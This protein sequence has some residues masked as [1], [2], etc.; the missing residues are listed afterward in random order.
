MVIFCYFLYNRKS[1]TTENGLTCLS[2][3]NLQNVFGWPF[4][5]FSVQV[6]QSSEELSFHVKHI[7]SHYS[8]RKDMTNPPISCAA[9]SL[10]C[11]LEWER[12]K[13]GIDLTLRTCVNLSQTSKIPA[14]QTPTSRV[15]SSAYK[16]DAGTQYT[17]LH[18]SW[19]TQRQ[20]AHHLLSGIADGSRS[21]LPVSLFSPRHLPC[22]SQG[23]N[24]GG[25]EGSEYGSTWQ[26]F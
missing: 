20:K 6:R 5:L 2:F 17:H 11:T 23:F 12:I 25:D 10:L 4:R 9:I 13:R 21:W 16:G 26:K 18:N 24:S 3:S 15:S 14:K 19:E 8:C 7:P 1:I 22:K